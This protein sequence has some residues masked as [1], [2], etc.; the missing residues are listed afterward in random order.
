MS[1]VVINCLTTGISGLDRVLAGGLP[2]FSFNVIAGP[3]GSGKT[4]L[5][6]Q[7]MFAMVEH[8]A[9]ALY[10]TVLSEPPLKM[11]RYQ[12]QFDF[13]DQ[14]KLGRSI[15]FINLAE[16][17][18]DGDLKL[19]LQRIVAEV[20]AHEPA[21]VFIDSFR[22]AI[23]AGDPERHSHIRLQQFMQQLVHLLTSWHVTSFLIGEYLSED[24]GNPIFTVADGLFWLRQSVQRN[25]MVRK[26]EIMKMRGQPIVPGLHTYR[27]CSNKGIEVF[28]PSDSMMR[29][30]ETLPLP[31]DVRRLSM[32]I[33]HLDEM[34]GGG[35]PG[36]YSLLVV[37]PSGSGKTILATAFLAEGVARGETGVIANFEHNPFRSSNPRL[38]AL[39]QDGHVSLLDSRA[40]DLSIDELAL[41]L[42]DEVR[43]L[44]A[45]RVVIDSLSGFELSL[46]PTF[47]ADFR[48]SLARLIKTL[49]SI[50]VTVLLISELEDDY[51]TLRLSPYGT[52][53][54]ADAIIMHRYIE[55]ESQLLRAMAVVKIRGSRHSNQLRQFTIDDQGIHLGETLADQEGLLG[56]QPSAGPDD[57]CP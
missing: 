5:A 51:T 16:E 30:G 47:R 1:K 33:E 26:L 31:E 23:L 57:D 36:G 7:I 35:L 11:L 43:R 41:R 27:I 2:E 20:Q 13:F 37:G 50:G 40:P 45:D 18:F 53:F 19:V 44:Q 49:A 3:P 39:I 6:H 14:D 54:L 24:V 34:M 55:V 46:A 28:A 29:T 56:G 22:S 21:L 8:Q 9:P 52:A 25:S 10:F 48:E 15:H 4:T 17:T 42:V 12:Q 38:A 32:G